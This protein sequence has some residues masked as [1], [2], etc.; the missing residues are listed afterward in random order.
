MDGQITL[1]HKFDATCSICLSVTVGMDR[2]TT[3]LACTEHPVMRALSGQ[4]ERVGWSTYPGMKTF[5]KVEPG[6]TVCK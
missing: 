4:M 5:P 3:G 1:I 2:Q 6:P